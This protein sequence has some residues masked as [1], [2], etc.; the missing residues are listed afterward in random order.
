MILSTKHKFIFWH[1]PKAAGT[2]VRDRLEPLGLVLDNLFG[3][4]WLARYPSPRDWRHINQEDFRQEIAVTGIQTRN[5]KEIA[6]VRNPYHRAVSLYNFSKYHPRQD[7]VGRPWN[8][9]PDHTFDQYFENEMSRTD[10]AWTSLPQTHW[11]ENPLNAAGVKVFKVENLPVAWNE[12]QEYI[13]V[14]LLPLDRYNVTAEISP[15]EL[16][17]IDQLTQQQRDQI[18]EYY[19]SDFEAFDY[20]R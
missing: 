18:Y 2:S 13:G 20:Q 3:H 19:R 7:R 4:D 12:L 11:T 9:T 10:M 6:F 5:Y 15:Y 17:T 8:S 14:K 16:M 1:V